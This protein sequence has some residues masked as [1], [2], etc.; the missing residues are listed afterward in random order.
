MRGKKI[1]QPQNPFKAIL[2]LARWKTSGEPT[3][4]KEIDVDPTVSKALKGRFSRYIDYS[5]E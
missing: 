4:S 5:S 1:G 3:I 2:L